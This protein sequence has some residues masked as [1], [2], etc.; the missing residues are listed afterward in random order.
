MIP[1]QVVL[2]P[3]VFRN[4]Y[5][6]KNQADEAVADKAESN[7]SFQSVDKQKQ[8]NTPKTPLQVLSELS[9]N[10][11]EMNNNEINNND[12][13]TLTDDDNRNADDEIDS[14]PETI[15][16]EDAQ[17]QLLPLPEPT[18]SPVQIS[19]APPLDTF[20]SNDELV[21]SSVEEYV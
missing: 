19:E 11:Q 6:Q 18:L 10:M 3:F 8:L 15:I 17:N 14:F 4:Q 5:H 21:Y 13:E 20:T 12:D 9:S 7:T 1:T 16:S 2:E